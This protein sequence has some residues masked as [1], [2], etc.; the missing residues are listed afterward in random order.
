MNETYVEAK[1]K[2]SILSLDV[3]NVIYLGIKRVFDIVIAIIGCII[4]IPL[5][6]IVKIS[7]IL[8]GDFHS[9]FF[10]Q[11]RIGKNGKPIQIYK[12]RT[13]VP[14]ADAVLFKLMEENEDIRIEY[15]RYKKLHHDPRITKMGGFL[16]STSID[17]MPQFINILKGNMSVVGP[18]P[19]LYREQKDMGEYFNTIIKCKP[20]LTGYSQVNGRSGTDFIKRLV[21]DEYYESHK[22]LLMDTKIFIKTFIKVFIKDGAK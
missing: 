16:R 7:Y 8:T 4:L 17:E 12:F 19:Y 9:I 22:G 1:E 13:M 15:K 14:N 3:S 20:G 6:V 2:E 11:E 18:R 21:M 5:I 10:K